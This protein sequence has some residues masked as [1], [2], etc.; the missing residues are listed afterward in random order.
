MDQTLPL[1]VERLWEG[2]GLVVKRILAKKPSRTGTGTTSLK[3]TNFSLV[4]TSLKKWYPR[5]LLLTRV[6]RSSA[7]VFSG[8][9]ERWRAGHGQC[10]GEETRNMNTQFYI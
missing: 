7:Q 9:P 4:P 5:G 2:R 3:P 1:R 8:Y 6:A 10:P